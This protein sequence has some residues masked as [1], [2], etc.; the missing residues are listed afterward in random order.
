MCTLFSSFFAALVFYVLFSG[1]GILWKLLLTTGYNECVTIL[2]TKNVGLGCHRTELYL[3][4]LVISFSLGFS[5]E[6]TV[7]FSNSYLS[8]GIDRV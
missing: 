8:L 1:P 5:R 6:T 4:R 7:I 2:W 3:G